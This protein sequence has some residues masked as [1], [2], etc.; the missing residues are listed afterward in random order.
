MTPSKVPFIV[1]ATAVM[2]APALTVYDIIADY[3]NGHPHILPPAFTALTVEEGGVGAGTR[4]RFSMKVLGRTQNFQATVEE[5]EPGR[6]L[7]ERNVGE[8]VSVTTFT[9]NP[10]GP[11]ESEVTISTELH[12]RTGLLGAVERFLTRRF[13][14]PLYVAELQRLAAR[15]MTTPGK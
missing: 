1:A 13:L 10:R 9:V 5:P 12:V 11:A 8:P 7:V 3:R 14:Q 2:A 15:A 6:V 4:I